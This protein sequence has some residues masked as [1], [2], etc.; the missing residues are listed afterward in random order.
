MDKK[1]KTSKKT[2]K[3]TK[4]CMRKAASKAKYPRHT[5]EKALRIPKAILRQNASM[6][7]FLKKKIHLL[8][9]NKEWEYR[10]IAVNKADDGEPGNTVMAVL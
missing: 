4:P 3:T 2:A 9:H 1:K 10:I 7:R 6:A 5:L 8:R